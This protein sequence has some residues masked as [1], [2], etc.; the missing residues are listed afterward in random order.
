MGEHLDDLRKVFEVF[1]DANIK[2]KRD[3]CAFGL[4]TVPF[5]GFV[6]D[7]K[8]IHPSQDKVDAI[9]SYPTRRNVKD[10]RSFNGLANYYR[11]F[12]PNFAG[13]MKPLYD[14]TK[15]DKKFMWDDQCKV[16]F[17]KIKKS[18]VMDVVMVHPDYG[19][20]FIIA[21]DAS[22]TAVGA[23]ISQEDE[24][25]NLRPIAFAGKTLNDADTR[26]S[27]TDRELLGVKYALEKFCHYVLG[28][29]FTVFTDHAAL[30]ALNAKKNLSG[31]MLRWLDFFMQYDFE[32]KHLKGKLS[33]VADTLS[34]RDYPLRKSEQP[35]TDKS[36]KILK[37]VTFNRVHAIEPYSQGDG[38]ENYPIRMYRPLPILKGTNTFGAH[39]IKS[40]GDG[41]GTKPGS[42]VIDQGIE[43]TSQEPCRDENV[44]FM[45]VSQPRE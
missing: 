27:T 2:F 36:T 3:K 21:T 40:D 9:L 5:L 39:D 19:K 12:I 41:P 4:Q 44:S 7:G 10:V 17:E 20:P 11:V 14:L 25:G 38:L 26:Y 15:K 28:S 13:I 33:V 24:N 22:S 23:C 42:P 18:I 30:V 43:H 37:R 8:G 6:I 32:M 16:A 45:E 1:R 31:R 35:Q 34:R 29:R